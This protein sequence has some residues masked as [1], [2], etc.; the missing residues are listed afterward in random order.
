[1]QTGEAQWTQQEKEVARTAFNRAYERET[2]AL[3]DTIRRQAS[4][5]SEL[6]DI[7]NLND[8]L[9]ARRFDID[10]KY[11]YQYSQLLFTFARL[12]KEGWL[13][14]DDLEGLAP[15]KLAKLSALSRM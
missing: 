4:Q 15:T 6:D 9:S 11:D 14:L 10:G 2:R 3:I 1:M 8:F 7:W 13:Q 12:V 5:A